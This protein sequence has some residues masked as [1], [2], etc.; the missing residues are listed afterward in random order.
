MNDAEMIEQRRAAFVNAFNRADVDAIAE[1][2]TEDLVSMPPNQLPLMGKEA[3]RTWFK[4]GFKAA[5]SRLSESIQALQVLG[6]WAIERVTWTLELQSTGGGVPA[7]DNGKGLHIWRRDAE[8]WRVAQAIWN[9]DNPMPSTI[10]SGHSE[11]HEP[12]P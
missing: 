1:F 12:E 3:S 6:D 9:S 10:W 11:V 2:L 8:T 5:P 4:E 7:K